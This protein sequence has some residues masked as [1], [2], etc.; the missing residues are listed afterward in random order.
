MGSNPFDSGCD[1]PDVNAYTVLGANISAV[2]TTSKNAATNFL[3]FIISFILVLSLL[4]LV[5]S[6]SLFHY[7]QRQL[8]LYRIVYHGKTVSYPFPAPH[9]P[10]AQKP[11]CIH[12]F[13]L[14]RSQ[15][16]GKSMA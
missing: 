16:S 5:F 8:S 7:K 2:K 4:A 6:S 12:N 15:F 9:C 10:F 13:L 11:P 3:Y 1:G 14:C